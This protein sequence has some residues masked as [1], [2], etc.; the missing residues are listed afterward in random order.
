MRR[1]LFSDYPQPWRTILRLSM[2]LFFVAFS[3]WIWWA[4]DEAALFW[5]VLAIPVSQLLLLWA[6]RA[7]GV[8][9]PWMAGQ[10]KRP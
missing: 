1:W 9:P 10:D 8:G 7:R 2:A 3:G 5:V 6:L 4:S